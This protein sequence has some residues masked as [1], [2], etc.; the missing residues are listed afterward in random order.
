V[1]LGFDPTVFPT[2]WLWGVF[3]GWR[4]H[5]LLLTELCTSRPGSLATAVVDGS[6]ATLAAGATLETEVTVTV[7][8]SFDPDAPGD[9]DPLRRA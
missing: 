7:S 9:V 4:G 3:G 6:A 5:H 2:P 8:R 1:R